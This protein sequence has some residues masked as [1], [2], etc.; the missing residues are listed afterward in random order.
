MTKRIRNAP[1]RIRTTGAAPITVNLGRGRTTEITGTLA[2][3]IRGIA[4]DCGTGIADVIGDAVLRYAAAR[5][6]LR[7]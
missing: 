7:P 2:A 1:R 5:R 6:G 3:D 4:R